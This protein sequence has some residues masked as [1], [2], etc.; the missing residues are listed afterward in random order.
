MPKD[1]CSTAW[2]AQAAG[3]SFARSPTN[4]VTKQAQNAGRTP[5]L[6]RTRIYYPRQSLGEDGL[7]AFSVPTLP[8]T[9]RERDPHWSALDRQIPKPPL[10]RAVPGRR[11]DLTSRTCRCSAELLRPDNPEAINQRH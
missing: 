1:S 4:P 10:I 2:K 6:L 9:N 5:Y 8:S 7:P 11:G 3:E